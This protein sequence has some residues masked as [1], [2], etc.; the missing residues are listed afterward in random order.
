MNYGWPVLLWSEN[1][2]NPGFIFRYTTVLTWLSRSIKYLRHKPQRLPASAYEAYSLVQPMLRPIL[3]HLWGLNEKTH[4]SGSLCRCFHHT[5]SIPVG[6]QWSRLRA[7]T[8]PFWLLW[9]W[10]CVSRC[11]LR[12]RRCIFGMVVHVIHGLPFHIFSSRRSRRDDID[13]WTR[14]RRLFSCRLLWLTH[15]CR[16]HWNIWR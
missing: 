4:P 16:L 15:A 11:L 13:S 6:S 12:P 8:N 5:P 14:C 9:K 10:G 1:G 3:I 2:L 7:V